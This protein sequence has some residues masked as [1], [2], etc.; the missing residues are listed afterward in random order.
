MLQRTLEGA[1]RNLGPRYLQRAVVGQL[2]LIH[3]LLL[4]NICALGLYVEL[5]SGEFAL[6]VGTAVSGMAAYNL[7]YGRAARACLAPVKRW[8][9]GDRSRASTV[10]A[11]KACASFPREMMRRESSGRLGAIG[12]SGLLIWSAFAT[13]VLVLPWY[14]LFPMAA[15]VAVFVLYAQAL[16]FFALEQVLRPVL[17]DIAGE[18]SEEVDLYAPALPLRVRLLA[19]LPAINVITAV[20]VAGIFQ[21]GSD[22]VDLGLAVLMSVLV[23]ATISLAL[24][25]LLADSVTAPLAA[26][27]DASR[28]V[29]RGDFDVRVPVL[30]TD[31]TGELA[32]SFNEMAAGLAE[33]ERIREAFG[34]YVDQEVAEHILR[35]GTDLAGEELEVTMMFIDVRDFTGFAERSSAPEVV[36]TINRLFE[37]AVPII[38]GHHGHVD[39]F[40]GDGLLA[41]FGA[42]RRQHD[43]ADQAFAAACAI[44]EAVK[45]EFGDELEIGIGL[46]TGSV[47]AGNVGGAGR[48]E[49]SVIG[50]PVNV[51]ARVEAAT[52]KTGDTILIA[53]RTRDLLDSPGIELVERS[54]V[55]LKGKREAVRLFA[56]R[57]DTNAK[58]AEARERSR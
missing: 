27:T 17:R 48:L 54:D 26:L 3:P 38:H 19:A 39:K 24:T 34:T 21:S 10:G 9:E 25:L 22:I 43:H 30:T 2:Q 7:L 58:E 14:A 37:R 12:Y 41:V 5:H 16:R 50:D 28:R 18:A 57:V 45:S 32:R 52:R 46:N 42:P 56:P 13:W 47:V 33:R 40:V 53:E 23:A 55:S 51:A 20:P 35:E 49:F 11:W 31:E 44:A 6:L 8:L 29:G 1:Y 15:G 36:A 4:F